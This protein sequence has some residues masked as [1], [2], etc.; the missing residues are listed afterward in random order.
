[1]TPF[2][3]ADS[4]GKSFGGRRILT[5]ASLRAVS[6]ELRLL[7]GRNGIGKST[8]MQIATGIQRAD[9]GVVLCDGAAYL[10]PDHATLA[11]SGV[12]WVP[13]DHFFSRSFTVGRQLDWL[14]RRFAGASVRE[15]AE[16]FGVGGLL[17]RH[18][19]SLSGGERRR[20]ELAAIA[21]RRP[22]CV[23]ADEPLRGVAPVDHDLVLGALREVARS[24]TAVVVSGHDVHALLAW[25]D[26]VTW[27]SDGTTYELG[28][29]S[30]AV[31]DTRF[32]AGYL[33][34]GQAPRLPTT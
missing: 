21:V 16:R 19:G 29:P 7:L 2:L 15:A 20:A 10:E 28:P 31:R 13:D 33:G 14:H 5:A 11:R 25:A 3:T 4:V 6:G 12:L 1:M 34:P 22:R 30:D 9:T 18:I 23:L 17:D 26:H 24:G 32:R 8:L 27:V